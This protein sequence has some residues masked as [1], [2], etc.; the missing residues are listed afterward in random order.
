MSIRTINYPLFVVSVIIA[1]VLSIALFPVEWMQWRPDW[2]GLI[3]FYWVYRAPESF[4]V[5]VAWVLGLMLDV[6]QSTVLGVNAISMAVLAF[7]V[8]ATHHRLRLYPL[9]QQCLMVFLLLGI[10]QMLVH[11]IKQ[12]LDGDT[13][14]FA[15]LYPAISSVFAWPFVAGILDL[16]NRKLS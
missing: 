5:L 16:L 13:A 12:M 15:Y 4:G 10:N 3:V 11:F 8:L 7:L 14:G 1:M 6:L 9:L 2:L